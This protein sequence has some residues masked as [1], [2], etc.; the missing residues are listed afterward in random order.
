MKFSDFKKNLSVINSKIK[1]VGDAQ[2]ALKPLK[3]I[4]PERYK[5]RELAMI[6]EETYI[7]GFFCI[8]DESNNFAVSMIPAM[9]RTEPDRINRLTVDDQPFTVLEYDV[10]SK[11][12]SNSNVLMNDNLVYKIYNELLELA[13]IPFYYDYED[14]PKFFRETPKYNGFPLGSDPVMLEYLT[15]FMYRNPDDLSQSFRLLDN[16]RK[17]LSTTEPILVGLNDVSVGSSNFI[18]KVTKSYTTDGITSG[19][20]NPAV[21]A[22]RIETMLRT[23]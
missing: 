14:V 10:G 9:I 11:I 12:I 6:G 8:C 1:T 20:N 4:F 7:V 13:R 23:T 22:E 19:L 2:V 5:D 21:R 16:A 3:I 18:T 15:A 17:R